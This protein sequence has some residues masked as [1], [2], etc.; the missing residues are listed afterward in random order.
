MEEAE[1]RGRWKAR[2]RGVGA[3]TLSRE[4]VS[5]FFVCFELFSFFFLFLFLGW[6]R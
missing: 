5:L 1:G 4:L 3:G 6:L 2:R